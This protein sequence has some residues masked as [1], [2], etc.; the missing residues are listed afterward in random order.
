MNDALFA[1]GVL[2]SGLLARLGSPAQQLRCCIR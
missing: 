1:Q 2:A